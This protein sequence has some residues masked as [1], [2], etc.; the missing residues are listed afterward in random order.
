MARAI[1][2]IE[3]HEPTAAELQAESLGQIIDALASN[4]EAILKTIG[5]VKELN[6]AGMLDIASAALENRTELGM[7]GVKL[8]N[9]LN[10]P[11]LVRNLLTMVEMFGSIDPLEMN[12]LIHALGN[13]LGQISEIDP[14]NRQY[15]DHIDKEPPGMLALLK[16]MRDPDVRTT[17][18]FG[19]HFLKAMGGEL[20]KPKP[21]EEDV[22]SDPRGKQNGNYP[23]V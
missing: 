7:H 16:M 19:L 23:E 20:N 21:E 15:G 18:T 17:M 9:T 2:R 22:Y 3:R 8:I 10:I 5:I 12:R 1:N 11:P 6:D 14:T 4:K 13:S